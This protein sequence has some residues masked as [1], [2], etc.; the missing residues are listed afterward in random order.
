[1]RLG[2]QQGNSGVMQLGGS[3]GA[4]WRGPST[5]CYKLSAASARVWRLHGSAGARHLQACRSALLD[6]GQ[7]AC[8]FGWPQVKKA[9]PSKG[10][11]Q[12]NFDP[13]KVR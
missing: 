10:V 12:P 1:M 2:D 13:V 7:L 8:L 11:I 6:D 9:S 4:A 3:T 5:A